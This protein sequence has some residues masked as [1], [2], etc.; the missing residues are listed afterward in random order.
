[1]TGYIVVTRGASMGRARTLQ[2]AGAI[3]IVF[4]SDGVVPGQAQFNIDDRDFENIYVPICQS[5][6]RYTTPVLDQLEPDQ[7]VEAVFDPSEIN[8]WDQLSKEGYVIFL[9]VSCSAFILTNLGL[10]FYRVGLF[11]KYV[12]CTIGLA[13]ICLAAEIIANSIRFVYTAVDPAFTRSIITY[14]PSSILLTI[15]FPFTFTSIIL[16]TF[17]WY[18]IIS[19]SSLKIYK[20]MGKSLKPCIVAI[21]L[22]FL[23]E[24]ATNVTRSIGAG[25]NVSLLVLGVIY[26]VFGVAF[27]IFYWL[28]AAKVI[29]FLKQRAQQLSNADKMLR[30]TTTRIM[31]AGIFIIC[32]IA[33]AIFLVTPF[34]RIPTAFILF[35]Y[36]VYMCLNAQSM[37][38]I[39]AFAPNPHRGASSRASNKS[40]DDKTGTSLTQMTPREKANSVEQ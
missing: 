36:A 24:I 11:I 34:L 19:S 40:T 32:F 16:I 12:G 6:L 23:A 22:I 4:S 3:A 13:Q 25:V 37:A 39:L 18:D 28:T 33:A 27:S 26:A 35:W 20:F 30:K 2:A 15:S 17:Y 38:S 21:G 14:T 1:M 31:V 9:Q 8:E 10:A 5:L 7:P 29:N